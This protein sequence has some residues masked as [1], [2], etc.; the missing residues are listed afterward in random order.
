MLLL[1]PFYCSGA[2]QFC[3]QEM[4]QPQQEPPS[5]FSV[6]DAAFRSTQFF[7]VM[8]GQYLDNRESQGQMLKRCARN[9]DGHSEARLLAELPYRLE[10]LEHGTCMYFRQ[11]G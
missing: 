10:L 5:A 1:Q 4:C 6:Q 2:R 11:R 9:M 7:R 8:A 3:I